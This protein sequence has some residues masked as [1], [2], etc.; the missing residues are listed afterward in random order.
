M[1][2]LQK[3]LRR[4]LDDQLPDLGKVLIGVSGGADSNA[5]LD[6]MVAV[7][8]HERVTVGHLNHGL[9]E[10][11]GDDV[12]FVQKTAVS[13]Q[14][15]FY[16]KSINITT[17]AKENSLSIEEAGRIARYQFL[18]ETARKIGATAVCVAHHADD[19]AETVLMHLLRGSG[20][21]G[22]RGMQMVRPM[23]N[24]DDL[25][26]IRPFLSTTRQEIETYCKEHHV[27]YVQ[28]ET[29]ESVDYFRN[30]IRH[31][32]IPYLSAFNPRIKDRLQTLTEIVAADY[33]L[34]DQQLQ[35]AWQDVLIGQDAGW[36]KFD[37]VK[38]Q[39]LPLSLKRSTL[40]MAVG[41]LRPFQ[42]NIG[43]RTIEQARLLVEKG[44]VGAQAVLPGETYLL[45]GYNTVTIALDLSQLPND[46]PLLQKD[47]PQILMIP[48]EIELQ[49]GW[50]LQAEQAESFD[51]E[52]IENNSDVWQAFV[53]SDAEQFV[54]RG[55]VA[56]ERF[57]PLGMGGHSTKSNM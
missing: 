53:A 3:R 50:V 21:S 43:F 13:L 6:C 36:L 9:R 18:V 40:R 8:G 15:P 51:L 27:A 52:K 23:P 57:Q 28:D 16:T 30:R 45:N 39:N 46:L 24:A 49:N 2:D 11:S 42:A 19:Q 20:L 29:N 54:V 55:R 1:S 10:V 22:L 31:Q 4:F 32:L 47:A 33:D 48:G 26:L 12:L 5:L 17:F 14:T 41:Q 38:W 34:L 35:E 7:I 44:Q 25:L 37:K 56:G